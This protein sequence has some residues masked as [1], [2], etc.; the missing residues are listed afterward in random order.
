[1]YVKYAYVT[2]STLEVDPPLLR[3]V[4]EIVFRYDGDRC[5]ATVNVQRPYC[6]RAWHRL[7]KQYNCFRWFEGN[8]K[9]FSLGA[10]FKEKVCLNLVWM[11]AHARKYNR[12]QEMESYYLAMREKRGKLADQPDN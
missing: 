5:G 4:T 11:T 6:L 2:E 12:A 1:M 8:R 7:P 9:L 3:S 10:Y